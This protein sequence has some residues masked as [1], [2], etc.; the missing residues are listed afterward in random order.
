MK[1][2]RKNIDKLLIGSEFQQIK[3]DKKSIRRISRIMVQKFNKEELN[4]IERKS[5]SMG[6]KDFKMDE[7]V[8]IR[9]LN[10]AQQN[11]ENEEIR[12]MDQLKAT[13]Q[14]G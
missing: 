1:F 4:K 9:S 13:C 10:N 7:Y 14:F 11:H 6:Q 3:K 2:I 5:R 12:Q 8:K